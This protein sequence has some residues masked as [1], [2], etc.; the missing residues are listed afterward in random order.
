MRIGYAYQFQE[1]EESVELL[2]INAELIK[3]VQRHSELE[4]INC[5]LQHKLN[6]V[7][8]EYFLASHV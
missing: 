6:E 8:A 7:L 3:A 2:Q 4:K 5:E 1:T